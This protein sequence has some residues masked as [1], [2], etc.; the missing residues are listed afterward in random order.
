M[1]IS[2]R[3]FKGKKTVILVIGLRIS[4]KNVGM[5]VT[6]PT[7]LERGFVQAQTRAHGAKHLASA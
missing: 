6:P 4:G 2:K 1:N 7:P 3:K 5:D